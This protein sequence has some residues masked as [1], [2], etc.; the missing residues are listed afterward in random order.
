MG[1]KVFGRVHDNGLFAKVRTRRYLPSMSPGREEQEARSVQ[2][3][4]VPHRRTMEE[5]NTSQSERGQH[6]NKR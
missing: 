5:L 4:P 6:V 3:P 1:E 2:S